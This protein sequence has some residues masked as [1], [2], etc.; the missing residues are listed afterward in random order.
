MRY[1]R[2]LLVLLAC[3]SSLSLAG[4]FGGG[5]PSDLTKTFNLTGKVT[6]VGT[7]HPVTAHPV[8]GAL[9]EVGQSRTF[10]NAQGLYQL[11]GL[12]TAWDDPRVTNSKWYRDY[13]GERV[14]WQ[15]RENA[16]IRRGEE[17]LKR[18]GIVIN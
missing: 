7:G 15:Q 9:V 18:L 16:A 1:G 17:I 2:V 6:S 10:T 12:T 11:T 5:G 14:H 8:P 3:L 4:C 13:V